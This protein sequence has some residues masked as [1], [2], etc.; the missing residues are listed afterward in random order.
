MASDSESRHKET[1]VIEFLTHD[2]KLWGNI[3]K[4]LKSSVE[5]ALLTEAQKDAAKRALLSGSEKVR[6][7]AICELGEHHAQPPVVKDRP[8]QWAR[9]T[10]FFFEVKRPAREAEHSA[11]SRARV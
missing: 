9:T 8:V 1:D 10:L 6:R 7:V 11:V 5:A 4:Q 3:H 2:R